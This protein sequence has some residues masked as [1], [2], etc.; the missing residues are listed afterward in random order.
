MACRMEI[1]PA[2]S[3]ANLVDHFTGLNQEAAT[4][5]Y[6]QLEFPSKMHLRLEA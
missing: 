5:K 3:V 1:I 2:A 4:M 6:L